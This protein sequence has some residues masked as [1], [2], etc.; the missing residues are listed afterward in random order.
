MKFL[1]SLQ[2]HANLAILK[3]TTLGAASLLPG[4]AH[5]GPLDGM[6]DSVCNMIAPLVGKSKVVSLVFLI[7]LGVMIFLWWMSE[8]KEGVITW[9]LRTGLAIGV[10]I[11]IF[12]LPT[13]MGLPAVCSGY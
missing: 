1:S 9:I 12:T 5:A 10:L 4:M 3:Y 6:V 13:M 11:N 7:A 2:E 8:N